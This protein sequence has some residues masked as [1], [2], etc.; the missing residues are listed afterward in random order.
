MKF[1]QLLTL[2]FVIAKIFGYV[3]WSWWMVFTPIYV[4]FILHVLLY[5]AKRHDL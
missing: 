2:V 5:I 4:V 3:N 1:P